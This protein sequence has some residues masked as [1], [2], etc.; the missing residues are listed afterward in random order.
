MGVD[1]RINFIAKRS[2]AQQVLMCGLLLAVAIVCI[3]FALDMDAD[4]Q[5]DGR[6]SSKIKDAPGAYQGM[7]V[8]LICIGV[9]SSVLLGITAYFSVKQSN[10]CLK[11]GDDD[12]F[13]SSVSNDEKEKPSIIWGTVNSS[14]FSKKK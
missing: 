13:I 1:L 10:L 3:I 14:V 2:V 6:T 7:Y 11:P 12:S 9:L 8:G 5:I 4:Y